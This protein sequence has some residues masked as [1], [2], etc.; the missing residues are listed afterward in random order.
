MTTVLKIGRTAVLGVAL[1]LG[2]ASGAEVMAQDATQV[3][4]QV[5]NQAEEVVQ[6]DDGG[7]E[8]GLLGLLGLGGLAG[9]ARRPKPVVHEDPNRSHTTTNVRRVGDRTL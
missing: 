6:E 9:L 4:G 1:A 3:A 5:Q 8:W 2:A 7:F